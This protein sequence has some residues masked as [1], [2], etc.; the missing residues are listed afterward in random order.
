MVEEIGCQRQTGIVV[1]MPSQVASSTGTPAPSAGG[2]HQQHQQHQQQQHQQQQHQQQ[3]QQQHQHQQQQQQHL[4]QQQHHQLQQQQQ[5]QQHQ[6][7]ASNMSLLTVKGGRYLWTDRELLMHLQNY[8]PLILLIDFVEKTRTKRFYESSER[9]EILMLVFIMRKGAPFC[10]N[11]RFPAEYWVNLS[12]GPIAEAFDRLQAAID[13]PDPQLPIHMSVTDLTSWK[14]M[15]DLAML[16]IRRFA[17]YTDPLQL[18][19]AGVF[20][21]ITFEQRFGMQWQE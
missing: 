2:I 15:F 21:R 11:K 3:Q 4:Q 14:Q 17:Y 13:I 18:A 8:T 6:Q 9:Y 20:N 10:E 19:D 12:V 5:Q 7:L 1:A 16:D